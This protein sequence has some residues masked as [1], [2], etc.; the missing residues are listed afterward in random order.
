VPLPRQS[1]SNTV[2]F[3]S[4]PAVDGEIQVPSRTQAIAIVEGLGIF[5]DLSLHPV[6]AELA[7]AS[8]MQH[9]QVQNDDDI[10]ASQA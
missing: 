1:P 4:A 2:K 8:E 10:E 3:D 6:P 7:S 9:A 5:M